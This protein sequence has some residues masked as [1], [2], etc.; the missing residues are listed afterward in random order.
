MSR[1]QSL[2]QAEF[3]DRVLLIKR[4]EQ[5]GLR[6]VAGVEVHMNRT[7]LVSVTKRRILRVH[8]GFAYASDNVLAAV[9][10]FVSPW[11]VA[12]DRQAAQRAIVDFPVDRFTGSARR[13]RPSRQGDRRHITRLRERHKVLNDRF[14]EGMLDKI[15]FRISNRMQTRLA[16]ILVDSG[17]NAAV[18]ITISRR[19]I[20]NDGWEEVEH[21]LLHEMVHQWQVESGLEMDHGPMF[22]R[23]A[24][25]VGIEPLAVRDV[26]PVRP[27]ML[28]LC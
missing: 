23:R 17:C 6:G 14:F 1:H 27:L 18:E 12:G 9:L 20:E 13:K 19:H 28:E 24:K 21:T 4:L 2:R 5:L 10:R 26:R 15:G 11:T 16:E 3:A 8:R 22:R 7:V 25:E